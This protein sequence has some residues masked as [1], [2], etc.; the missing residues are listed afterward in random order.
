MFE[1]KINYQLV[2]DYNHSSYGQTSKR[3]M[4]GDTKTIPWEGNVSNHELFRRHE[5]KFFLG[6]DWDPQDFDHR[7]EIMGLVISGM[8]DS[9]TVPIIG[10]TTVIKCPGPAHK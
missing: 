7:I 6:T 9:F 8:Q 1:I 4:R 3:T 5:T 10:G 2:Y